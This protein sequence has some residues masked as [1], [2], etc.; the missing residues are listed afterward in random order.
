MKV[1]LK[2]S[3]LKLA[4]YAL[5]AFWLNANRAF[6]PW[7]AKSGKSRAEH[8]S[9]TILGEFGP[10]LANIGNMLL[11]ISDISLISQRFPMRGYFERVCHLKIATLA[12]TP[13]AYSKH[14]FE[15]FIDR[16]KEEERNAW[17]KERQRKKGVRRAVSCWVPT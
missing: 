3:I 17:E 7:T 11:A 5:V 6:P 12:I 9:A 14:C 2:L 1:A 10:S 4:S 15:H 13:K 8:G 16:C